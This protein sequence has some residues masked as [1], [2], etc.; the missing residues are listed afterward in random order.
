MSFK[1][2]SISM[3]CGCMTAT[4]DGALSMKE[5]DRLTV[6]GR[7]YGDGWIEVQ[8]VSGNVGYV[9]S[10]YVDCQFSI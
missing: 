3:H 8:D 4:C 5:G 7:D 1:L 9:P 6:V 10:S 2:I